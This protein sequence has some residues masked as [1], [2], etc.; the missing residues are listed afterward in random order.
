[1]QK[2]IFKIDSF[3]HI[4]LKDEEMLLCWMVPGWLLIMQDDPG[5][6]LVV[7]DGSKTVPGGVGWLQDGS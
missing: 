4:V 2:T 3:K 1:M 7:L 6:F 5:W